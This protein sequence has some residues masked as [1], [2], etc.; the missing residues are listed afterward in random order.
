MFFIFQSS[1]QLAVDI[2]STGK[3]RATYGKS[4]QKVVVFGPSVTDGQWHWAR[5]NVTLGNLFVTVDNTLYLEK[6]NITNLERTLYL[7]SPPD[8]D[9]F[10]GLISAHTFSGCVK[11]VQ[12]NKQSV[13][14]EQ[15]SIVHGKPKP[16]SGCMKDLNCDP[17]PC[18]N[19]GHC[20][21]KFTGYSCQCL[22]DFYGQTCQN[23]T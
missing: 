21:G 14:F 11:D 19:S 22:D 15:G 20:V 12:I 18:A 6:K 5:V 4:L 16:S 9:L 7:G 2:L 23:G 8:R 13:M 10:L 1:G 17:N 3:I